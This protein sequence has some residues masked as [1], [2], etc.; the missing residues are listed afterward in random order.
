MVEAGKKERERKKGSGSWYVLLHEG[1]QVV[2]AEVLEVVG[3]GLALPRLHGL[4]GRGAGG[5]V[6]GRE[7]V[8]LAAGGKLIRRLVLSFLRSCPLA[9]S[10]LRQVAVL[11][12]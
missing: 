2:L 3:D 4:A 10:D 9:L 5:R 6:R 7:R 12:V 1:E 8:V 11:C